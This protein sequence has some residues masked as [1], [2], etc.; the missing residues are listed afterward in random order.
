MIEIR[1]VVVL[2]DGVFILRRDGTLVPLL[3][4]GH[5]RP[6]TA[7]ATARPHREST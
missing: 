7:H 3:A 4:G 5:P 2:D 1:A 6:G